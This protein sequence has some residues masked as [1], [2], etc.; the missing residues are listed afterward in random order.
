MTSTYQYRPIPDLTDDNAGA[1][2][3]LWDEY[4]AHW[5]DYIR[6]GDATWS[7]LVTVFKQVDRKEELLAVL[8]LRL[9]ETDQ[10]EYSRGYVKGFRDGED[11]QRIGKVKS[12]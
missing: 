6:K 7:D 1:V 11:E 2:E 10:R 8:L 3:A 12:R 9:A 5:V 4:G